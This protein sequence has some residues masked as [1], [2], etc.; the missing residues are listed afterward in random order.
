M[1]KAEN[2]ASAQQALLKRA[3]LNHLAMLGEYQAA[4]KKD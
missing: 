2:L 4:L 3:R 1:G